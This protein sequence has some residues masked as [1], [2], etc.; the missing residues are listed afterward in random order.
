MATDFRRHTSLDRLFSLLDQGLKTTLAPGAGVSRAG[1]PNPAQG[2]PPAALSGEERR[3]SAGLMRVNHAGEI[4]AQGLYQG[5]AFVA[6]DP[7][8]RSYLN[9]AAHEEGDH[10]AW[11]GERLAELDA[12]PSRLNPLWYAG[13]VAL[14]AGFA[15]A[16]DALSLGFV[17]ETEKQVEQ[18]L[19][20]H[21]QRL[22][23]HDEASRQIV[24]AMRSDEIRHG[25]DALAAG[26]RPLPA[27]VQWAMRAV[28]R[29]MTR[30][31]YRF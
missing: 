4:A 31:A 29:V 24:A 30:T 7:A 22:P 25:A 18:H 20:D 6:R 5:Q 17:V 9:A 13:S 23:A 28:S 8:L 14:G 2:T 19:T 27:P 1:R 15:L 16:G 11:C 3:H 26:A 10:L 21:L 12:R